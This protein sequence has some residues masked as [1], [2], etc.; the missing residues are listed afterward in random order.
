MQTLR[1]GSSGPDVVAWQRI[2][3]V[4]AD[5]KFG[6]ATQ[7][8][9]INWQRQHKLAADGIVG[10][11][12]WAA[13]EGKKPPAKAQ[14]TATIETDDWAFHVMQKAIGDKATA[15]EIQYALTVARGEGFYG[16]GWTGEGAGSNNW[17]AVQGTGPAGSFQHLDHHADGSPYHTAFK[18]YET[19][20]QG[21]ADMA[22]ILLKAN[23]RGFVNAGKLKKAVYAQHSNGYYELAPEKYYDAVKRNYGVLTA[24]LEWP[25]LL[26]RWFQPVV[27]LLGLVR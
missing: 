4:P 14:K 1:L 8:G 25:K 9:T 20:E 7:N 11:N 24:N 13:A 2:I 3:G 15:P 16:K 10:P 27:K 19:P 21:A 26:T 23:V 17:G 5:G 18:R 12:T 22:R 6:P